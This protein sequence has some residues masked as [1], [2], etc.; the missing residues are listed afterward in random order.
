MRAGAWATN[1]DIAAA[2]SELGARPPGR[3]RAAR[4]RS[5]PHRDAHRAAHPAVR[6]R[7]PGPCGHLPA[8]ASTSSG[9]C[10]RAAGDKASLAIGMAG[11][12]V[13]APMHGRIREASRLASEHMALIES[14]G[15]PTLT[16]GLS[17]PGDRYAKCSDRRDDRGA[18]VVA[19][20]HRPGR[21]R[22][23]KGN[24]IF[25]SPLAFALATR[26]TARWAWVVRMAR[27]LRPGA[28]HGPQRR[29][30]V[31]CAG[32]SLSAWCRRYRAGCCWPTTPRC[33]T[34]R[35][36]WRIAERSGDDSRWAWPG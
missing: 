30:D 28:G 6:H 21:R 35:K 23:S 31:A 19:A 1:R 22:P 33:A 29:P 36:R 27:R 11:L 5:G 3:R 12:V 16:V 10:A 13:R 2:R 24:F 14:I 34:S 17:S 8:A 15:D 4:R 18:A 9:S 7:M 20:R 32:S 26:G 25:G